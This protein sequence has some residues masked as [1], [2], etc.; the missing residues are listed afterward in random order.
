MHNVSGAM[1][2]LLYFI[3]YSFLGWCSET[4]YA[5]Y[6]TKNFINRGF[7]Y[8][9]FC[10]LYGIGVTAMLFLLN[11]LKHNAILFFLGAVILTST[12]EYFTGYLLEIIF[13]RNWWDYSSDFLNIHG[14]VCIPFSLIWGLA[15][16]FLIRYLHP[17]IANAVYNISYQYKVIILILFFSYFLVDLILTLMSLGK[18]KS[19][20]GILSHL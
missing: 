3:I 18:L 9:P 14:R 12:I 7:L 20:Q 19:L 15:S 11:P 5:L 16:I 8:G 10:P 4:L 1:S 2:Y 13:N 17:L 6:E